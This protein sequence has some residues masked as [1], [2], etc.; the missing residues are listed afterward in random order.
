MGA[1]FGAVAAL[2]TAWRHPG[3]VR[4]ACCVQ[5]GSFAFTDIGL[6]HERGPA[7][8]PVVRFMNRL[9]RRRRDDRATGFSC[10]CGT[11]E[12]LIYENRSLVPLLQA[13][14]M[15]V[16]YIEATGRAQL[17]ELARSTARRAGVA[18][19]RSA[20]DGL[21]MTARAAALPHRESPFVRTL[22]LRPVVRTRYHPV[23]SRRAYEAIG[24]SLGADLCWPLCY[25][26]ILNQIGGEFHWEV[27]TIRVRSERRHDRT[28]QSAAGHA[29]TTSSSTGS[30]TGITRAA[31]G[32]RSP[33]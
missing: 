6:D 12:S 2:S 20:L 27:E 1:S 11:Y 3:D 4:T 21:R 22:R 9:P 26:A 10:R 14:G 28:V 19:P 32:S 5:S 33:S 15:D 31:S 23:V 29:G 24:L 13:T 18:L 16:R 17:G 8:D 30:R 7:F 25:E